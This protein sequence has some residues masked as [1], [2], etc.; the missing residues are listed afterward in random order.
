MKTGNRTNSRIIP[1]GV[2]LVTYIGHNDFARVYQYTR[3]LY[4][5]DNNLLVMS[6]GFPVS[7]G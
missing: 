2:V 4:I 7:L 6:G 5:L 3:V 1:G